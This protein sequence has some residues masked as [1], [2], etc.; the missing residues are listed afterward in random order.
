MVN[1]VELAAVRSAHHRVVAGA[2][3]LAAGAE[4][5]QGAH[6][7]DRLAPLAGIVDRP[8]R[9][10]PHAIGR[11]LPVA[12][13]EGLIQ[14]ALPRQDERPHHRVPLHAPLLLHPRADILS[15]LPW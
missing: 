15:V 5:R 12:A 6:A 4:D 14:E 3:H 7:V 9:R 11:A 8:A 1:T 10:V 13:A 2:D